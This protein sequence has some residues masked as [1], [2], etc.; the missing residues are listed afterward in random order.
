M[1]SVLGLAG[2]Y[3]VANLEAFK[4]IGWGKEDL[5]VLTE[6][7]EWARAVPQVPGSYIT[8]RAIDNA[9]VSVITEDQNMNPTDALYKACEEINAELEIKR[10]ELSYGR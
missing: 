7:L 10:K 3:P 5:A 9:F 4:R 2:R 6:S 1:E 8:G